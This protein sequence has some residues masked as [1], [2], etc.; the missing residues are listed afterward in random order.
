M[1]L[2]MHSKLMSDAGTNIPE[3]IKHVFTTPA[4]SHYPV[5]L[6][7][8]NIMYFKFLAGD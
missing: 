1:T 6:K 3:W 8:N 2:L 5:H 4:L 7:R